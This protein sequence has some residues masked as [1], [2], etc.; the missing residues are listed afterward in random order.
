MRDQ[1]L[2]RALVADIRRHGDTASAERMRRWEESAEMLRVMGLTEIEKCMEGGWAGFDI[3]G[4]LGMDLGWEFEKG[5]RVRVEEEAFAPDQ[6]IVGRRM[7]RGRKEEHGECR[8]KKRVK[9]VHGKVGEDE[10]EVGKRVVKQGKRKAKELDAV[11]NASPSRKPSR[12]RSRAVDEKES[13]RFR[14]A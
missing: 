12:K 9:A 1:R 14:R 5:W 11:S 10:K 8:E 6:E 4:T 3:R 7:K 13:K 2:Y